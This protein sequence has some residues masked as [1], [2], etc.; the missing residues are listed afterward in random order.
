[1]RLSNRKLNPGLALPPG[2]TH[3][4]STRMSAPWVKPNPLMICQ[5]S[6]SKHAHPNPADRVH[7]NRPLG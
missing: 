3:S 5:G 6:P 4:I 2:V 1:M 7:P